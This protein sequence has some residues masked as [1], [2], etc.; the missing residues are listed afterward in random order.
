MEMRHKDE[1]TIMIIYYNN[2][3]IIF[4]GIAVAYL[5]SAQRPVS[6]LHS[7]HFIMQLIDPYHP[8]YE[9][10]N[11]RITTMILCF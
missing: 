8:R 1:F 3:G 2:D 4:S 10:F 5:A 6:E 9:S 11:S 7:S